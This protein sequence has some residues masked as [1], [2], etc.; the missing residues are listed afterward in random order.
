MIYDDETEKTTDF[1]EYHA[2]R[3]RSNL[4]YRIMQTSHM[5]KAELNYILGIALQS[6]FAKH[7][8]D[9]TNDFSQLI[10]CRKMERWNSLHQQKACEPNIGV[11][12]LKQSI[13]INQRQAAANRACVEVDIDATPS[14]PGEQ[15]NL[16]LVVKDF[17]GADIKLLRYEV[18]P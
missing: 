18:S 3:F 2:D 17:K 4:R 1:N 7:Y 15:H 8:C 5:N 12:K 11:H 13:S 14:N 16:S 6:T 10:L 9:Y